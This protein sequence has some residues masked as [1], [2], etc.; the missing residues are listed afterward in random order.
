VNTDSATAT[1]VDVDVVAMGG[2]LPGRAEAR[3][4]WGRQGPS[5]NA[6]PQLVSPTG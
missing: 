6:S 1:A 4:G 5:D 2:H 3:E